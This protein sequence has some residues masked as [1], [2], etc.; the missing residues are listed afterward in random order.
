MIN[1]SFFFIVQE[2]RMLFLKYFPLTGA[3]PLEYMSVN[4]V[5]YFLN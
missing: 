4:L 3:L 5:W 1:L 2:V